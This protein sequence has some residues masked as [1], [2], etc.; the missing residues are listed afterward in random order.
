LSSEPLLDTN[1]GTM[2]GEEL[3]NSVQEQVARDEANAPVLERRF[4]NVEDYA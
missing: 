2:T 4:A 1:N 3:T